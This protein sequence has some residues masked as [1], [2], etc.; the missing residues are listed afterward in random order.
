MEDSTTDTEPEEEEEKD[1]KDQENPVYAIAPT[2]NIQDERLVDLSTT[3][4]FICLHELH[5]MGKLPGTRMAE[6][7]AKYTLLH[8]TVI[9]TQESEVQ[10]LQDA[11]RFTKQIQ[12]Q[13]F[14]LQQA[15]NFPEAFTTE[16][17]KMREQLLK[18]QNEYNAVKEREFHN[19]YRLNS[20]TEEKNLIIKEFEKIPKPGEMEKKMRILRE[21]TEELRKETMQKKLEIK[22][23]REDLASK[24]KQLLK[25]QKEL[26]ELLE[27]QV[28]LKDEV[29]HHQAVPVQIGKEIEKTT[30]KKVEMEKKKIVLEYELEELNDFLKKV[31]T[32]INSIMEEKEDVIKEVEGKRALL[33]IKEREYNQLVKLSELTRENE[34]TSLTE[35]GILD[36]NLRNC[37]IDKQNYHDELSRKQREKERD[38]RNLRKMELL[39]KVSCDA[40][41][42][43][44]A[45][46][47]RL[48]LEIE[49]IPK[50]DSTLSERRRELH[51]EVEVAKRNLAQ[52]KILSEAESKLVEQQLAEENKLLKEQENMRELAFNLVRMTQIKIDEKEQKS[53]D[54]LKAQQKYTNIVKEIKAKDLEI[55]IHKKK[56]REI[57]RR[58]REFAKL[59]DTVRN[60]RN[61]FVNLLHKA[62]QKVNEI[63]ERHKMSL[64]EL[65]I[66]RNSAVTQER[67]LQ[68]SM[69][70]L[71]NNVT[72]RESMQND[73]CKIVAKLQAMKEKKE[74]QLNNID[75]LANMITV[76]EEEMVQLRKR[77]EKA[78]QHRN[79]SGVQLIE[80]E[81]EVCIFYEK[82][83][84]QEKMK[85]NGEIE[86]HVLEEKIRFLKLKIAEKQRQIHVTQKLLPTKK[87]LDADLAVLQIQFS[88]CTDRIR[89]LEKQL[90]N[91]EGENRTRF[92][93]GKD[94]TQEEMIKKLDSMNGYRKKIKDATEKM[95]ALV[96]ELSMKQALAI[97]LQKEVMDKED[98]IFSCNSRIEKGL[99]L[100]KDI[101][102]EWLKVLRDEEIYALAIAEK[103]QEF[104]AADIRQ[105][106][107]GVYTTAE[108]R[109]N[110]YIPEAEAALPLPK[111][112]GALAP[113]KPSEPGANMRHIRK[114]VIKPI[115]I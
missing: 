59:Y 34:A 55:R 10:L 3:P 7:K 19:Q 8:D 31:E 107:N 18:Y 73:V 93:P 111:P 112:Y 1:E 13:Q 41:T 23:L 57:H 54:F 42:Q 29:V 97:E 109:P 82:I 60:E 94:M 50:D 99:P 72:I 88:Q 48:L 16:V 69:L 36:L 32:K 39:L 79:E 20:L 6:L 35:R 2:I 91:P 40:L 114:P 43:T 86:I 81:E 90:I 98:F 80:R 64:N 47:Q 56:K 100:N 44:Q 66:L 49:A 84:I 67:K 62:H 74:V 102:R 38:F 12:Q 70:K 61:K 71:A 58:L 113:F 22:N 87:A 104:L 68:N 25:E 108:P 21:S 4:A 101:E 46:H 45:L 65:E 92:I 110:A 11:K 26:E 24:Q 95:M 75:R 37:L 9:S 77:Y 30:R 76:I 96:A 85:L 53:K 83:N 52:Q 33:E 27:Y 28:N 51:K 103:S 115:E 15:D 105:L 17:S 89:D 14:H 63:K 5:A 106:P 78:V